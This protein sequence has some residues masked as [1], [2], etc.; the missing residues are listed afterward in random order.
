MASRSPQTAGNNWRDLPSTP[1]STPPPGHSCL[2][3][4]ERPF[5]DDDLSP[6][7]RQRGYEGWY[8]GRS[9]SGEGIALLVRTSRLHPEAVR[10]VQLVEALPAGPETVGGF[11]D[12]VAGR[13]EGTLLA[14][15]RERESGRQL[16]AGCTHLFWNPQ[17]PDIKVRQAGRQA[18]GFLPPFP[19]RVCILCPRAGEGHIVLPLV[20]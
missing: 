8:Q 10:G 19:L 16:V 17:W 14:V 15:L 4:V 12:A 13:G 9:G 1:P 7:L 18:S 11:W 6:L 20:A 5:F 2:Q 3:E